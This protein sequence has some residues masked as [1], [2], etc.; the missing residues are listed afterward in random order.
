M[1]C[2][3]E[4]AVRER[5]LAKIRE[6][7]SLPTE[8]VALLKDEMSYLEVQDVLSELIESGRVTLDSNLHLH[9][10]QLAA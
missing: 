6:R 1:V 2:M 7:S 3:V 10:K 5:V 9:A 8:L 4:P